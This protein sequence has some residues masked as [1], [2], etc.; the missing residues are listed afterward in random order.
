MPDVL[1]LGGGL[2]GTAAALHLADRGLTSVIVE[3]RSRLG[4]R[5]FSAPLPGD[6]GPPVEY[7]GS[8]AAARHHRLRSLAAR[9]GLT[10]TPRPPALPQAHA[11]EGQR[12]AAPCP[13][14]EAAA[15]AAAMAQWQADA[16]TAD[17]ALLSLPLAAYF[18]RRAMPPSAR[19][20]IL[21]WWAIS[22][23][24]D[25]A[26]ARVSQLLDGKLATGFAAKLEELAFT[27]AGG[28]Q[29]LATAMAQASGAGLVLSDPATRLQQTGSAVTA[30]LASGRTVT[31]RAALVALPVNTLAQIR[32][33]PP[34]PDV[35]AT[36]RREGHIGR[37]LKLLI[38]ARGIAPGALVTGNAL[39]LRFLWADHLRPDGSTLIIAF[40]LADDLPDP[41]ES[42]AKAALGQAF[43]GAE[44]LSADWHDWLADPFAR[45]TW[46]APRADLE[47]LHTA[48]HWRPFGRIA[49]A[50]SD[51][52]P[53][54]QGWFEGALASAEQ[55]A[56]D[57]ARLLGA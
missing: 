55:A 17:P 15:H 43:P 11:Y 10:L 39:G 9:F 26:L 24:A 30:Q 34:L 50:G 49:F 18:D 27:V 3:A 40:A 54:E 19:R 47:D 53:A 5:A 52:A 45:G 42:H 57:L 1:I 48:P 44:F 38:R 33:S 31:A 2:A 37:A 22:G 6:P 32:F 23:S 7:G 8:W 25:P 21:S 28:I 14:S 56:E 4:G 29:S 35:P 20:E 41:T 46:V 13:P 16:A 36:L 12:H 51:I